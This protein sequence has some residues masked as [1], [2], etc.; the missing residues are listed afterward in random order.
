MTMK[1][2]TINLSE[3]LISCLDTL[4]DL[5]FYPSRSEAV[6]QALKQFLYKEAKLIKAIEPE[7]FR[8]AKEFQMNA[9]IGGT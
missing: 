6:R 4:R 1:I 2:C 3:Q 7:N 9:L 5:G 8:E